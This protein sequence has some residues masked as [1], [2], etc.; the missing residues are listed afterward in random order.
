MVFLLFLSILCIFYHF[1]YCFVLWWFIDAFIFF[2]NNRTLYG[3]FNH[4]LDEQNGRHAIKMISHVWHPSD[5][6]ICVYWGSDVLCC[7]VVG[8]IKTLTCFLYW[9]T[10][11]FRYMTVIFLRITHERHPIARPQGRAM[12][13]RSWVKMCPKSYHWNYCALI[14]YNRDI[15]KV[16]GNFHTTFC[17]SQDEDWGH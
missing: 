2:P 10:V 11:H 4:S 15:S 5:I 6:M 3:I 12:G 14:I 16:Y 1:C 9:Y 17:N 13:C 7:P 8:T